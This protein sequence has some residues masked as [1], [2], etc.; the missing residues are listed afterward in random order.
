MNISDLELNK[1]ETDSADRR[2]IF[3]A[4]IL[5]AHFRGFHG[6]YDITLTPPGGAPVTE[7]FV[8]DP[9]TGIEEVTITVV[10]SDGDG[11]PGA[12]ECIADLDGDGAVGIGDFLLEGPVSAGGGRISRSPAAPCSRRS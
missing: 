4:G 12:C 1:E 3:T 9:G 7:Q 8:L 2:E 10:D 5:I 6:T 11:V